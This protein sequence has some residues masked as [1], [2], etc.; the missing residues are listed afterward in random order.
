MKIGLTVWLMAI[1][2]LP[3]GVSAQE[4][5]TEI[6]TDRPD[7]SNTPFIVPK[8][9]IQLETGFIMERDN[10]GART[11]SNYSYNNTLIKYG[12]NENF[13]LHVKLEYAGTRLGPEN[14]STVRGFSPLAIGVK[15]KLADEKGFLPQAAMVSHIT[16][17]TGSKEFA[18][19]NTAADITFALT[20]TINSRLSFSHNWGV[21]WDGELPNAIFFYT[22]SAGY[23][24]TNKLGV[25]LESY[26]YLPEKMTADHRMDGGLTFKVTPVIQ[27]DASGGIGLSAQAPDYFLSTG[28]SF[29]FLK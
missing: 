19:T 7:Q 9:A 24:L 25:F 21:M 12:V 10:S 2:F 15:M 14:I 13:E 27:L 18:P 26:G 1:L 20:H 11:V 23:T 4:E 3:L 28:I 17:I 5:K 22:L 16:L 29:R 8:G 6:S